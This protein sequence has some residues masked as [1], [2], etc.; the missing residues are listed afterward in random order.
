ML[1]DTEV[2]TVL[3]KRKVWVQVVVIASISAAITQM[4]KEMVYILLES[5]TR[6]SSLRHQFFSL[7]SLYLNFLDYEAQRLNFN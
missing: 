5:L 6:K 2:R 4:T 3:A 1:L 7:T